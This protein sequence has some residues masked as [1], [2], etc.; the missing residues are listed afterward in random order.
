MLERF[1]YGVVAEDERVAVHGGEVGG[2]GPLVHE[3]HFER[4][5]RIV[6]G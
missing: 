3:P 5:G 4:S 6:G 2:C 1:G